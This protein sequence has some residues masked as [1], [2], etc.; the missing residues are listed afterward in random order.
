ML[1]FIDSGCQKHDLLQFNLQGLTTL[2]IMGVVANL[3]QD[4]SYHTYT[5]EHGKTHRLSF[6]IHG[7]SHRLIPRGL[8]V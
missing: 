2:V 7:K 1:K 8:E 6:Q 5:C 3:P 4:G